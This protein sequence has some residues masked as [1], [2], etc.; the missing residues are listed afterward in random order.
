M[1]EQVFI[2]GTI[3]WTDKEKTREKFEKAEQMININI[4]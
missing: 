4:Y 3:S 2:S 1:K